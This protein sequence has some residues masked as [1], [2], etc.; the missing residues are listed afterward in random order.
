MLLT[1]CGEGNALVG[2]GGFYFRGEGALQG[3]SLVNNCHAL[4]T[5][6]DP[7]HRFRPATFPP[8]FAVYVDPE[9][10]PSAAWM[11]QQHFSFARNQV[12][13]GDPVAVWRQFVVVRGRDAGV[14]LF[15]SGSCSSSPRF[16]QSS[17]AF[18]AG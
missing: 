1:P 4:A 7:R 8:E 10:A 12:F 6:P 17:L 15:P 18:F 3:Y 14:V 2:K 5:L 9:P 16:R 13:D 11:E